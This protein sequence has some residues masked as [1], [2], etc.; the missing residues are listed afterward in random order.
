MK[1]RSLTFRRFGAFAER[2]LA[3]GSNGRDLHVVYGP[4]E[5]GK[6]TALLGLRYFLFGFPHEKTRDFRFSAGE[7]RISATLVDRDGGILEAVRRRGRVNTLREPDDTTPIA[8]DRLK[9]LL[10][11]LDQVQF[12]MLFG[13]DHDRLTAGGREIASGQG[14]L[15]QAIFEAGAGLSGLGRIDKRLG[16]RLESLFKKSGSVQPI[17]VALKQLT[18]ERQALKEKGIA[19]EAWLAQRESLETAARR[20]KEIERERTE[21]RTEQNRLKAYQAAFPTLQA[22]VGLKEQLRP[23][24]H[25]PR[26]SADFGEI[27]RKA[28]ED[29]KTAQSLRERH[30]QDAERAEAALADLP[31][32]SHVLAESQAILDIKEQ[33]GAVRKAAEDYEPLYA[34]MREHHGAA[35]T[36]LRTC[37]KIDDIAAAESLRVSQAEQDRIRQLGAERAGRLQ[38][39]E[40]CR[41]R[42]AQLDSR[43]AEYERELAET[44][45]RVD[46]IPLE[47][48][49]R[50]ILAEGDLED[51]KRRKA[52]AFRQEREAIDRDV[53]CL[54]PYWT[55][56]A[57]DLRV[58]NP[59][60]L[61]RVSSFEASLTQLDAEVRGIESQRE[62]HA[63]QER[64]FRRRIEALQ[65][66]GKIPDE[67]DL[68]SARR[69]RD[70][71]IEDLAVATESRETIA[72]A[73]RSHV[74]ESDDLADQMRREVGRVSEIA[75]NNAGLRAAQ[76]EQTACRDLL[77]EKSRARA[78]ILERWKQEWAPAGI[79][80]GEPAA[81]RLWRE[82]WIGLRERIAALETCRAEVIRL[83]GLID[84]LKSEARTALAWDDVDRKMSLKQMHDRL[85]GTISAVRSAREAR[86]AT[87][88]S[89]RDAKAERDAAQRKLT[90]AEAKLAAWRG[91]WDRA[92]AGIG[93][94]ADAEPATANRYL[95]HL[96]EV[97]RELREAQTI[98]LR[99]KGIERD[100]GQFLDRLEALRG[101]LGISSGP[102]IDIEKLDVAVDEL[103]RRGKE[104]E[105]RQREREKI[106]RDLSEAKKA[107]A[108]ADGQVLRSRAR[109]QSLAETAGFAAIE[110]LPGII[111]NAERRRQ[112][113]ERL[114]HERDRLRHHAGERD[115]T[116][117]VADAQ[118]SRETIVARLADVER[119]LDA[120]D[121]ELP[122]CVREA[123]AAREQLEAWRQAS[124]EA[125]D[126]Q[127]AIESLLP[128]LEEQI[129]EYAAVHLARQILKRTIQRFSERRHDSLLSHAGRYFA[130]LT[131]GAFRGLDVD[132]SESGEV[133]L[134][135]VR[136]SND[137][138]LVD[139][140]SDGTRDQLFL[141]LRLAGIEQHLR[142]H[143]PMP[144]AIDDVL[145]NFDDARAAATL[146]CLAE[147]SK[148]TQVMLFTHH[149]H[150][151][152]IAK[153]VAA[154]EVCCHD[155]SA[156]RGERS[157]TTRD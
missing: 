87:T 19:V 61:E 151:V 118:S 135:A 6:S 143:G 80:P 108:A 78:E 153:C 42:M 68:A 63:Q 27:Y 133:M 106:E 146:K 47:S 18:G 115:L 11:G 60:P 8:E 2:S 16:E 101:R 81:M 155:L 109:L 117:F 154:D 44:T 138:V 112:I 141:A 76:E 57:K 137:P 83:D 120:I 147:L 23:V 5:A 24:A 84:Q 99:L 67:V 33:F 110:E 128:K 30:Q 132:E 145:V 105:L 66:T 48:L 116:E 38:L 34:R 73:V 4:N 50:T 102:A 71:A 1:F 103:V 144:I 29:S 136:D 91:E 32:E 127:Q 129:T 150:V 70:E 31:V 139:G 7:Q 53:A 123:Q 130:T 74:R 96:D 142:S 79:D 26:L 156:A 131:G 9:S 88:N 21:L 43:I 86:A 51:D 148:Q 124:A 46:L 17:A 94:S 90:E 93:L 125:A 39:V 40:S 12:D 3:F 56:T 37:F 114:A 100:R 157:L 36:T 77:A 52:E 149:A 45:P 119:R 28:I 82:R 85:R 152:E 64:E 54:A 122:Q 111:E 62:R 107:I 25:A 126:R 134:L 59:P 15:G 41:E 97:F 89:L 92:V 49:D 104:A 113:E 35:H 69:R 22:I 58:L 140:L 95:D 65:Q 75:L 98:E 14:H 55:G 13:I 72:D 121:R 20:E 10:G